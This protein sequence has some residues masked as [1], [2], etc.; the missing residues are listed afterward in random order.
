MAV[1]KKRHSKS[2]NKVISIL[3]KD[4]DFATQEAF[5]KIRTNL[6]FSTTG[7]GCKKVIVT[8]SVPDEGKS[9]VAANLAI[10][11][12]QAGQ[13]VLII[14][15]DLRN[16]TAHRFFKTNQL[17]GLSE[18]LA[19]L[20]DVN[21]CLMQ[22]GSMS[23]YL[24]TAGTIPPNPAELLGSEAM[25]KLLD[26]LSSFYDYIVI[27]STPVI[28]VSDTMNLVDKVHGVVVVVR[29]NMTEHKEVQQTLASLEYANAKI[30]GLVLNGSKEIR[31]K[32][33]SYGYG[34]PS[35]EK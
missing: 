28:V 10:S 2:D 5:K 17:P 15:A 3:K 35:S 9:M 26:K 34:N 23:L 27:D 30:L 1:F 31:Q 7:E 11:L 29:E 24:I 32:E 16:P 21:D 20:K 8:S 13:R 12:A 18:I 19:G 14:D 6:Q 25:S 22:L 4:T 33:Y